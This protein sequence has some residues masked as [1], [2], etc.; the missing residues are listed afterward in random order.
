MV[1]VWKSRG[2]QLEPLSRVDSGHKYRAPGTGR[3]FTRFKNR[4]SK[5]TLRQPNLLAVDDLQF[6][7]SLLLAA[8]EDEASIELVG[9]RRIAD[10]QG[11]SS[12]SEP[13]KVLLPRSQGSASRKTNFQSGPNQPMQI[14]VDSTSFSLVRPAGGRSSPTRGTCAHSRIVLSRRT[15]GPASPLSRTGLRFS[16]HQESAPIP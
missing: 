15:F 7:K 16:P 5:A 13:L 2:R 6:L 4:D 8:E 3:R 10:S 11:H 12:R 1:R 14:S 9:R